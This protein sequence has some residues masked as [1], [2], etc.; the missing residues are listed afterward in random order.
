MQ[1]AFFGHFRPSGSVQD[2]WRIDGIQQRIRNPGVRPQQRQ[3]RPK[4]CQKCQDFSRAVCQHFWRRE[5]PTRPQARSS[6]YSNSIN[7]WGKAGSR[8]S[9]RNRFGG[10]I[11]FSRINASRP[12]RS[13]GACHSGPRGS[14]R[15]IKVTH[16]QG[17]TAHEPGRQLGRQQFAQP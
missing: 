3:P 5:H 6:C 7:T 13:R 2:F 14:A 1:A 8:G 15:T 4:W 11:L 9:G 10:V 17:A 16:H 12:V